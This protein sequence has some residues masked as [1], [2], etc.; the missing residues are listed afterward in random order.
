MVFETLYAAGTTILPSEYYTHL[1]LAVVKLSLSTPLAQGRKRNRESFMAVPSLSPLCLVSIWS[2]H[3]RT[4]TV[5][6]SGEPSPRMAQLLAQL[7]A[8]AIAITFEPPDTPDTGTPATLV[9]LIR[10]TTPDEIIYAEQCNLTSI[11]TVCSSYPKSGTSGRGHICPRLAYWSHFLA[12]EPGLREPTADCVVR[13]LSVWGGRHARKTEG[14]RHEGYFYRPHVTLLLP[15]LL[16][17]P[18]QRDIRL[19]AIVNAFCTAAACMF[20]LTASFVVITVAI[21]DGGLACSLHSHIYAAST[22]RPGCPPFGSQAPRTDINSQS[23]PVVSDKVQRSNI[24][25]ISASPGK[26][27]SLLAADS[28]WGG[29]S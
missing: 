18:F 29:V 16:T 9:S 2:S 22:T 7:G 26:S 12:Q 19:I 25:A 17:A 11:R 28:S 21:Q 10:S 8:H 3:C 15:S 4:D 20:S 23:I 24:V 6:F 13:N 14:G 27:R 5:L 1:P